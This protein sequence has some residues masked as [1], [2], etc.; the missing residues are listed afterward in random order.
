M[1]VLKH[2]GSAS[3]ES[4]VSK[5]IEDG[6]S[7]ASNKTDNSESLY[8]RYES[9]V[10]TSSSTVS[11]QS[12]SAE[13][14]SSLLIS[15][16]SGVSLFTVLKPLSSS[17]FSCKRK[18]AKNPPTSKKRANSNSQSKQPQQRV[19]KYLNEQFTVTSGTSFTGRITTEREQQ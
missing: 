7:N 1:D 11:T 16:H 13:S 19:N 12:A 18:I 3:N 8:D 17:D 15:S 9:D 4:D 10:T 14:C 5:G 2:I 6:H